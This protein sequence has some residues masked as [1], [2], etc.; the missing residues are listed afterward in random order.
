[1][2]EFSL[3][4][5]DT[6]VPGPV[7]GDGRK[8]TDAEWRRAWRAML[9]SDDPSNEGVFFT[10][11]AGESPGRLGVTSPSANTIHVAVGIALVDGILYSNGAV[12][13]LSVS[14]ASPG[15]MRWD[16]VVL[17]ASWGAG[18]EQFR[19]RAY[20]KGG[21]AVSPPSLVR[22]RN[23]TWEVA[24]ARYRINDAGVISDLVDERVFIHLPTLVRADML[25]DGAV[26]AG[27]IAVG[28]VSA[29]GQLADNVV[30]N[31]KLR[32]S[33]A[34]SVMG[35]SA[36]TTGDPGDIVAGSDGQVLRR[37]GTAVEFGQVATAGVADRAVTPVKLGV[38]MT[39]DGRLSAQNNVDYG[40]FQTRNVVM[41]TAAPS[42][43]GNA[44]VWLRF[45]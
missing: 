18:G 40:V 19:A 29:T 12:R 41:S 10:S 22:S 26:V 27:K 2:A 25:N 3:P 8:Y 17:R 14:S 35:R 13:S 33:A 7:V 31:T 42:G 4:W 43:G 1:M 16:R 11:A 23:V 21:D 44:D 28:G 20:I 9:G 6:S 38:P 5:P 15:T 32:D 34:L 24:L 39:L 36:N 37:A 30:A 45:E